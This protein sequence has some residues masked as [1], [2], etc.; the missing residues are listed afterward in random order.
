MFSNSYSL[1][2]EICL[3]PRNVLSSNAA[4]AFASN[5]LAKAKVVV[6]DEHGEVNSPYLVPQSSL[7]LSISRF[8]LSADDGKQMD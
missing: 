1:L 6:V 5:V 4:E 7:S 3:L 8:A 2:V